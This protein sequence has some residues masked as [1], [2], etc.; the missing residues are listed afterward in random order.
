MATI[1]LHGLWTSR[2]VLRPVGSRAIQ[3]PETPLPA[4]ATPLT[5]QQNY[6]ALFIIRHHIH[7]DLKSEYL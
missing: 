1:T 6:A 3:P 7:P 4:G 5:E 2:S